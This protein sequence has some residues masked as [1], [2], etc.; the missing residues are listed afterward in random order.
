MYV[1]PLSAVSVFAQNQEKKPVVIMVI[2]Q[3][4]ITTASKEECKYQ[5]LIHEFHVSIF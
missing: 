4:K 2:N 3:Y 1:Y 5:N